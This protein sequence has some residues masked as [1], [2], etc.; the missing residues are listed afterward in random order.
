MDGYPMNALGRIINKDV[1]SIEIE[2]C[3][4]IVEKM[5]ADGQDVS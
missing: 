4:K 5:D 1:I 3:P 2:K